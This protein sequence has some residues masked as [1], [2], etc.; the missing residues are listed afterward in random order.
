MPGVY[1]E[2]ECPACGELHR[3][4]GAFCSQSCSSKGRTHD[5]ETK[6]KIARGN[7]QYANTPEGVRNRQM[8]SNGTAISIDE[9]AVDIPDFRDIRDYD[10]LENYP[11]DW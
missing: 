4:K 9:F 1:K 11:T 8:V 3:K 6:K 5:E 10:F 2:K 7:R